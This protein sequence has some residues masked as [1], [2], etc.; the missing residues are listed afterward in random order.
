M[1]M[2]MI[3]GIL[4]MPAA[5]KTAMR[6]FPPHAMMEVLVLHVLLLMLPP[7]MAITKQSEEQIAME[8][9]TD[10]VV[11]LLIIIMRVLVVRLPVLL[12]TV[13]AMTK[14]T[15]KHDPTLTLNR[16]LMGMIMMLLVLQ[17]LLTAMMMT[18]AEQSREQRPHPTSSSSL[19]QTKFLMI[20]L[21]SQSRNL[22]ALPWIERVKRPLKLQPPRSFDHVLLPIL[23][24]LQSVD[25]NGLRIL[26]NMQV[27]FAWKRVNF[28]NRIHAPVLSFR[29][30]LCNYGCEDAG[31]GQEHKDHGP[32]A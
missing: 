10:V 14:R 26:N 8:S 31:H 9:T 12:T 22:E 5:I 11:V 17:P 24:L 16:R 27:G 20:E 18:A 19:S 32:Q 6:R 29:N 30:L 21:I 28:G 7:V 13:K 4:K 2:M 23:L 3:L 15:G 25:N 1:M